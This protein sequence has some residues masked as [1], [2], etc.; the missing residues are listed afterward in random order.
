M[1]QVVI[2]KAAAADIPYIQEFTRNTF[3]WGDYVSEEVAGWIEADGD[4][5]VAD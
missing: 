3:E 4:V 5:W 1:N 2:R